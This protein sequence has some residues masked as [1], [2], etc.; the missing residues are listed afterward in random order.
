MVQ[1]SD[2]MIKSVCQD[3]RYWRK[4][5]CRPVQIGI[6]LSPSCL[7]HEDFY[8]KL[9]HALIENDVPPSQIEVEITENFC[10]GEPE[11]A[12]DQLNKLANIGVR[13]AIDDFGT[14]YSSLAYLHRF[15]IHTLKIDQSFVREIKENAVHF[16]V[17][18]AVISIAQGLKLDLIAEGVETTMQADY[19]EQAGCRTMQGFL[20]HRPMARAEFSQLIS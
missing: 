10:I 1:L 12:V 11:H 4:M 13:V 16:P 2:W 6:N 8:G 15:R 18:L 9:R 19:L 20:F 5:H 17:V 3:V 14:G 7:D